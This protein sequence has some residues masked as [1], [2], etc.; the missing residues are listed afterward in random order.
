MKRHLTI[1][2]VA[3]VVLTT[4]QLSWLA[5]FGQSDSLPSS[6]PST[7]NDGDPVRSSVAEDGAMSPITFSEFPTDTL[8]TNQYANLGIIFG[9]DSPFITPDTASPTSPVLSGTPL[10]R[11][12]II[13]TF[14]DPKDGKTPVAV[15]SFTL[16]AGYFNELASTR[17]EWFDPSGKRLGQRTNSV[18]GIEKFEIAGGNIASW[19]LSIVKTEP[20]GF[21]ID[22]VA[23]TPI[24]AAVLFRE[25]TDDKNKETWGAVEDDTPGFDHVGFH[26]EG[27]V[28]ESHP[29]YDPGVFV[30]EDG[31]V[32]VTVQAVDGVQAQHTFDTFK[33]DAQT[34]G[35]ENSPVIRFEAL[36]LT[37]T[38]A[39]SMVQKIETQIAAGATFQPV[40]FSSLE[41]ISQTL[42]PSIQKGRNGTFTG[43]GLVEWAAEQAGYGSGQGFV[44]NSFE[45][46]P[47]AELDWGLAPSV[48]FTE[49]PLLSPELLNYAMKT[50]LTLDNV[51]QWYQ[52]I[53]DPVDFMIT[54]PLG[55]KLGFTAAMGEKKEI[56]NAFYSGDGDVEQFL[57]PNPVAGMF[58]IGLVGTG[59]HVYA[60]F[61]SMQRSDGVN[62]N[63]AQGE[64]L[65]KTAYVQA[66]AGTPGDVDLDGCINEADHA[67]LATLLN[68]FPNGLFDPS[69]IDGNGIIE[70]ADLDLLDRLI[71]MNVP[72][73]GVTALPDLIVQ[74][75]LVTP[76]RVEVTV[77]NQGT[78]PVAAG[79][80]FRVD[81]YVDPTAAP[82][83]PNQ[84]WTDLSD[85]G[86][87]WIAGGDALPLQPGQTLVL[88]MGGAHYRR[89][90]SKFTGSVAVGTPVYAQVDSVNVQ[91]V[92][93]AVLE[94]H[95]VET[96]AY[97]NVADSVTGE[98][99]THLP[100][101]FQP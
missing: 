78:G 101:L 72:C 70:Q 87:V 44:L 95:E 51:V 1:I 88:T 53:L 47:V 85:E 56:P 98:A 86:V 82:T 71:A 63:L 69:D 39:Q 64:T 30:S 55:R 40:D 36:P 77:K 60:A 59:E 79:H 34:Q 22:N 26:V 61:G 41:T 42:S 45:S 29:G 19:K 81:L 12:D 91:T 17:I 25:S 24:G 74:D 2:V 14:V 97:N 31:A 58:Q 57:V 20:N 4:L 84:A 73:A 48:E 54:D 46:I 5:A 35:A 93:G 28:Y 90:L 49:F 96:A 11:G 83:Q 52:G 50:P 65:T 15:E 7:W 76:S 100:A 6:S 16:D 80:E 92:Y 10:F 13:G 89:D 43:V 8:I 99:K 18:Y 75:I 32:T 66:Q 23:F 9:G 68:T 27:L 94:S 62:L 38:L 67:K 37:G 33:H 3:A 21:G